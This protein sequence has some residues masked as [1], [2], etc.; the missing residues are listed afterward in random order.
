MNLLEKIINM[1]NEPISEELQ[2]Q[3]V[4]SYITL[5]QSYKFEPPAIKYL[6]GKFGFDIDIL[7]S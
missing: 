5:Q 4:D 6:L 2:S 7:V 3:L 1:G